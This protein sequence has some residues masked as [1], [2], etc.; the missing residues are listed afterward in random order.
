M[1][2]LHYSC[3]SELKPI[4][5]D[6]QRHHMKPRG[7]WLSVEGEHDWLAWC[8]AESFREHCLE[9]VFHVKLKA[10]CRM[11]HIAEVDQLDDFSE[12]F[13]GTQ[14]PGIDSRYH[15]DWPRVAAN[16]QGIIIAPYQWARRMTDHTFWYY[17]WDCASA[18]IWDAAA[19][20][21]VVKL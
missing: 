21:E 20:A 3:L 12:R 5:A 14:I 6:T 9:H 4:S 13:G 19:I 10:D 18:C 17:G 7:L 16:W 8:K 15:I 2:L 1:R 11:L